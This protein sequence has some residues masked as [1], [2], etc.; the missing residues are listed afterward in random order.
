M[1]PTSNL[2]DI[3]DSVLAAAVQVTRRE[4]NN[5]AVGVRFDGHWWPDLLAH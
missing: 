5:Y 3:T 2:K 4:D 1:N